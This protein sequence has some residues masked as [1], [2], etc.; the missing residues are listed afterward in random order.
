MKIKTLFFCFLQL[1]LCHGLFGQNNRSE[2]EV[3]CPTGQTIR[4]E[5]LN[6]TAVKVTFCDYHSVP[7]SLVIPDEVINPET[8]LSYFITQI[9]YKAFAGI[10]PASGHD[11]LVGSLTLP[12]RLVL[13]DGMAFYNCYQTSGSLVIP[14]GVVSIGINAFSDCGFEGN[15]Y[16]GNCIETIG[17]GAFSGCRSLEGTLT[18][19]E[20]ILSIDEQAFWKTGFH[21]LRYN[22]KNLVIP[23]FYNTG[24]FGDSNIEHLIFGEQVKHIP[25]YT[26]WEATRLSGTI[27]FPNSVETIGSYSFFRDSNITSVIFGKNLLS[28]GDYAFYFCSALLSIQCKSELPPVIGNDTFVFDNNDMIVMVPCGRVNDYRNAPYWSRF[29]NYSESFSSSVLVEVDDL[30]AG[31]ASIIQ[32]PSCDDN[33][34]RVKAEANEG[35]EFLYWTI[36]DVEVSMDMEY[37]FPVTDDITIMAH[38]E[39]VTECFEGHSDNNFIYPN[40]TKDYIQIASEGFCVMEI[41]DLDGH[42]VAKGSGDFMD[43]S[44]MAIGIYL[45]KIYDESGFVRI[46]RIVKE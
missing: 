12:S 11:Y 30:C 6:D 28:I 18:L 37:E 34:A 1:V 21:E 27:V 35:Y 24:I 17:Y 2:F 43:L 42:C 3:D 20:N 38:F 32:E 22:V 25:S 5:I 9:G 36:N 19:G 4:C 8:G 14:F 39:D 31:T 44:S 13:I 15:L 33:I 29:N 41:Y 45:V 7:N 10:G 26:F 46:E 16:L 23:S 40:P